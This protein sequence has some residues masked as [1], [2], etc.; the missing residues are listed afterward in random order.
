MQTSAW[1]GATV[2]T[3]PSIDACVHGPSRTTILEVL[4]IKTIQMRANKSEIT[5]SAH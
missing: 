2:Y 1:G 5:K 4:K 3:V